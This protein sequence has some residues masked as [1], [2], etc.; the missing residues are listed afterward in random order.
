MKRWIPPAPL[1]F[2]QVSLLASWVL[3]LI[4]GRESLFQASPIGLAWIH[5][6]VLGWIT[7]TALAF[8]VHVLPTFGD[9]VLK[10]E[11]LARSA[12][13]FFAA[14]TVAIVVGFALWIP[15]VVAA[16]G[17]V[18]TIAVL[19]ELASFFATL[20]SVLRSGE[21]TA[22]T[23]ARAFSI[24]FVILGVT[25]VLG[26]A[27]SLGLVTGEG[28]VFRLATIHAA[29]GILGWISLLVAG[30]S[31][32]TYKVLL[33]RTIGRTAHIAAPLLVLAGLVVLIAG[34]LFSSNGIAIAGGALIASGALVTCVATAHALREAQTTH[35]LPREFVTAADFW[36]F[37]A[38]VYGIAGLGGH[39]APA[40]LLLA[41]VLGWIGQNINAHMMHVGIRLVATIVISDD[42]ETLPS[43]L[44]NRRIGVVSLILWQAAVAS[45]VLG[46]TIASGAALEVSGWLGLTATLAVLANIAYAA[47]SA[48]RRRGLIVLR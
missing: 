27:M 36:L 5:A 13:W 38:I 43:E 26:F 16:G 33:G 8:L 9:T 15:V 41:I 10:L 40:A 35:R 45:A 6:V 32:R 31:A 4:A 48:S 7:S 21:T 24:V 30:V 1:I 29:L 3:L 28:F 47:R 14:G 19:C 2:A 23:I 25:V 18:V 39:G 34:T 46:V 17:C 37:V 42:D 11:R 44:L 12:I 22:R 20:A